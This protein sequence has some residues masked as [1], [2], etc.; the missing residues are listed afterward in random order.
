MTVVVLFHGHIFI[1]ASSENA[2]IEDNI[3]CF[4]LCL[5]L[6]APWSDGSAMWS[7][8]AALDLIYTEAAVGTGF[9][10]IQ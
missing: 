5:L 6:T 10:L 1:P 3:Q 4:M 2:F 7:V 9:C 8:A